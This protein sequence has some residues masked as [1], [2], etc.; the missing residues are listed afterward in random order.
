MGDEA[1]EMNLSHGVM[2][3]GLRTKR[4]LSSGER[5]EQVSGR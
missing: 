3:S 4:P 1:M 2:S 5:E